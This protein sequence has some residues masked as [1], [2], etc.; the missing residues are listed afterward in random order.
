MKQVPLGCASPYEETIDGLCVGATLAA[1]RSGRG[2]P[3][4]YEADTDKRSVGGGVLDA[5]K[6]VPLGYAPP[7]KSQ[8]RDR[9]H[10]SAESEG[11][12]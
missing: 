7:Y 1:V 10:E 12:L 5:V 4:P 2:K 6:Q 3:R 9:R 11:I 8:R